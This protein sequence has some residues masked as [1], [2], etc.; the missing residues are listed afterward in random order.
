MNSVY[1]VLLQWAAYRLPSGLK[2]TCLTTAPSVPGI[3]FPFMV[4]KVGAPGLDNMTA[5]IWFPVGDTHT[6]PT[7]VARITGL[8][9]TT[10]VSR[11]PSFST[12]T[13]WSAAVNCRLSP[14]YFTWRPSTTF[15]L[16]FATSACV[17]T[18]A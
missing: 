10:S 11:P 17:P 14:K 15:H 2:Y 13:R 1:V 16:V 4:R 5:A 18:Y 8:L 3:G 9:S 12:L 6:G 7:F